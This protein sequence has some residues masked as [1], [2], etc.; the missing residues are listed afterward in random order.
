VPSFQDS[1]EKGTVDINSKMEK[2]LDTYGVQ[3]KDSTQFPPDNNARQKVL[4]RMKLRTM[5]PERKIDLHGMTVEEAE[6]AL[7]NFINQCR[8]KSVNKILIIHGKGKHGMGEGKLRNMVRKYTERSSYIGETGHPSQREGGN[9]ALWCIL[10][11]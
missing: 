8:K 7:D 4:S 10:K 1:L 6:R 9:G 3:D 11:Y 5:Q 2:W